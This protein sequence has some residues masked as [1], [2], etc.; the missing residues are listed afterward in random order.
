[1]LQHILS[2]EDIWPGG[3][4][5]TIRLHP[6]DDWSEDEL[7]EESK[8]WCQFVEVCILFRVQHYRL[9]PSRKNGF[10]RLISTKRCS[11]DERSLKDGPPRI[12]TSEM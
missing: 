8:G 2:S 4:P 1:M 7:K 12:K 11:N 10:Q 6:N 5:L 3:I 9:T